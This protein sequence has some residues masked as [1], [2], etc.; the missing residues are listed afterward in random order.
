MNPAF[1]FS[2]RRVYIDPL[3]IG[4]LTSF[5][6]LAY[7]FKD[8]KTKLSCRAAGLAS[9]FRKDARDGARRRESGSRKFATANYA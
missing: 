7:S 8:K 6:L 5:E 3:N 1:I 4:P 2:E 9:E